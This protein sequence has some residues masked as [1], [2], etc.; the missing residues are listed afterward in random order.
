VEEKESSTFGEE[1][2]PS[3]PERENLFKAISHSKRGGHFAGEE[4]FCS[5]EGKKEGAL[6]GRRGK[7]FGGNS[8]EGVRLCKNSGKGVRLEKKS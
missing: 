6:Q 8:Q 3:L 4:K 7:A 1:G 2:F 5:G